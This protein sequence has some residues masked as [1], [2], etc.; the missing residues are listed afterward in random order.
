MG[1]SPHKWGG[2]LS[3]GRPYRA[4]CPSCHVRTRDA[5]TWKRALIGPAGLLT[6][7]SHFQSW[8][9][10]SSVLHKP[11]SLWY[12]SQHSEQTTALGQLKSWSL[13]RLQRLHSSSESDQRPFSGAINK[14]LRRGP[15]TESRH[16]SF[17]CLL[18]LLSLKIVQFYADDEERVWTDK[19]GWTFQVE[20]KV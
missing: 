18:P 17:P 9:K 8:E 19:N 4:C 1:W 11:P 3:Y 13:R 6:F 2:W 5:V 12:L 15:S 16:C 7:N 14:Y 20:G 10:H